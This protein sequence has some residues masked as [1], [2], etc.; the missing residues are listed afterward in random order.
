MLDFEVENIRIALIILLGAAAALLFVAC[1]NVASLLLARA[2]ARSR[3]TAVRV[4]IG[5]RIWQLA[6]QYFWEGL[7]ISLAATFAGSLLSFGLAR[8]VVSIASDE[9][10][11]AETIAFDRK[12]LSFA[13]AL[14]ILCS[15]CFSLSPLFGR[16]RVAARDILVEGNRASSTPRTRHLLRAFV[17]VQIALAFALCVISLEYVVRIFDLQNL[18]PGFTANRVTVAHVSVSN[19]TGDSDRARSAY[20]TKTIAT[21]QRLPGIEAAG[22]I[23]MFPLL[24]F[25]SNS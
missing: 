4:A 18:N 20:E 3:E 1:A 22:F 6:V 25:G 13:V 19:R 7:L 10:P 11:R 24:D 21:I 23:D 16:E 12:T 9:L 5:A 2:V 15:I 8:L 17:V 14:A